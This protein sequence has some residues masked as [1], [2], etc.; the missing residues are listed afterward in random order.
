MRTPLPYI[1]IAV[2][3]AGAALGV[4][5]QQTYQPAG[6]TASAASA[7]GVAQRGTSDPKAAAIERFRAVVPRIQERLPAA[8]EPEKLVSLSFDVRD[9][10]SLIAP[11]TGIVTFRTRHQ[12]Q[13]GKKSVD[14]VFGEHT[15]VYEWNAKYAWTDGKWQCVFVEKLNAEMDDRYS[16]LDEERNRIGLS[17]MR[18]GSREIKA[19]Q[20][21]KKRIWEHEQLEERDTPAVRVLVVAGESP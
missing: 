12:F 5:I 13:S 16:S 6:R 20:L 15:H 14:D 17:L 21:G 4:V 9:S 19:S 18:S 11:V 1:L 7:G 3:A 2:V 8:L 10:T